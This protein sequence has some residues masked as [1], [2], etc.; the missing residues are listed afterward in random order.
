MVVDVREGGPDGNRIVVPVPLVLAQAALVG[1]AEML[2]LLVAGERADERGDRGHVA[3]GRRTDRDRRLRLVR[4]QRRVPGRGAR[5]QQLDHRRRQRRH[6]ARAIALAATVLV[7]REPLR[8]ADVA[9]ALSLDALRGF[10]MFW[11]IGGGWILRG[12]AVA[13]EKRL[14]GAPRPGRPFGVEHGAIDRLDLT[15][16]LRPR[17]ETGDGAHSGSF[18]S[19]TARSKAW[20]GTPVR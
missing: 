10:D 6:Q 13:L 12:L 20:A 5:H 17:P 4:T 2:E 14:D 15:H 18:I 3:R 16:R 9:A 8:R 7:Y 1:I 11:I 19:G